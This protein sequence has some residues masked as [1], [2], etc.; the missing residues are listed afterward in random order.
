MKNEKYIANK[1]QVAAFNKV[2][3]AIQAAKK[4]GLVFYAKQWNIVAYTKEADN[5]IENIIG[6]ERSLRGG[7]G[8]VHNLSSN[9]LADSGADDYGSYATTEDNP[10][11]N[12]Y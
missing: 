4:T 6:F 8:Q 11:N 3:K 2:I 10:D 7:N 9:I 5:Y 12:T 1:S